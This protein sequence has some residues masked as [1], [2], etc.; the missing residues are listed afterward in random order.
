MVPGQVPRTIRFD[1]RDSLAGVSVCSVPFSLFPCLQPVAISTDDLASRTITVE[2]G[3][4]PGCKT[5]R[6]ACKNRLG[7]FPHSC[8]GVGQGKPEPKPWQSS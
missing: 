4:E 8:P 3:I 2:S 5:A 7:R 6:T 1:P